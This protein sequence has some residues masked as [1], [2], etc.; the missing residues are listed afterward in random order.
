MQKALIILVAAA[1]TFALFSCASAGSDYPTQEHNVE[2]TQPVHSPE[3]MGLHI[4]VFSGEM[5]PP[6]YIFY[7]DEHVDDVAEDIQR[8]MLLISADV[9]LY[10]LGIVFLST[11]I[12][13]GQEMFVVD[14][15]FDVTDALAPGEMIMIADFYSRGVLPWIGIVM[16]D[17]DGIMQ[18]YAIA[19]SQEDGAYML[20]AVNLACC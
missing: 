3:A 1:L 15:F 18:I 5:E 13:H 9:T 8:D 2:V 12:A 10:N 19:Q 20:T 16:D 17:A 7:I 6:P 4:G 11:R 14:D